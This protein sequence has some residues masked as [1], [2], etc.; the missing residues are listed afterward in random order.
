MASA[1]MVK[2][3]TVST[4]SITCLVIDTVVGR[5][6]DVVAHAGRVQVHVQR[7]VDQDVLL[8]LALLGIDSEDAA[9]EQVMDLN[10]V[11]AHR[12]SSRQVA[13]AVQVQ[14]L[15]GDEVRASE[16]EQQ[17]IACLLQRSPATKR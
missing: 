1:S 13:A 8:L 10:P 2:R 4:C 15:A 6:G 5:V 9:Q 7:Q 14:D 11:F 17:G 16:Q 3:L 12:L